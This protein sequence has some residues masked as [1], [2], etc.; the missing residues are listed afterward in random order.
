M[1]V[2]ALCQVCNA[3][4]RPAFRCGMCAMTVCSDCFD[5]NSGMCVLCTM[6]FGRRRKV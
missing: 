2:P 1:E 6:K 5:R 3:V 4:A